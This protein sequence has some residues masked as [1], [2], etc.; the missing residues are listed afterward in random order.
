M[1]LKG[2]LDPTK[3]AMHQHVLWV[4]EAG[5]KIR[6]RGVDAVAAQKDFNSA[7]EL[8][9]KA[10]EAYNRL[11]NAA[12]PVL[13]KLRSGDPRLT[14]DEKET[15]SYFVAFQKF[16]TTLYR[17]TLNAAAID[18]LRH[19]CRRILDEERVHEYVR[20]NSQEESG[21]VTVPLEEAEELIRD[22]ADGTIELEQTGTGWAL[23]GALEAGQKL[24]P[25]LVRIHWTLL[26]TPTSESWVTT[27]N[28]VA[29]LEPFPVRPKRCLGAQLH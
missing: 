15:F 11:E 18:Q 20:V 17:E 3:V 9:D 23:A 24:M 21:S 29:L 6:P 22:M 7:P 2:F 19:T 27:D 13:A 14:A 28:P 26:E 10:E 5:R 12:T 1:Y 8:G 25:M 16:R 4:Y